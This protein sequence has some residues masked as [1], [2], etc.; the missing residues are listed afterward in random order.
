MNIEFLNDTFKTYFE[1]GLEAKKAGNIAEAKRLLLLAADTLKQIADKSEGDLKLSRQR[2]VLNIL[3]TI[4]G[5]DGN[6]T[7]KGGFSADD[8]DPDEKEDDCDLTVTTRKTADVSARDELN[9]LIGLSGVKESV[10]D[11]TNLVIARLEKERRG[12]KSN[13][14]LSLHLVFTGNPGT[15]KTTVARI[16]GEIYKELGLLSGGH[17]VE[18]DRANLVGQF[19]GHT[20]PLVKKAVAKAAGG[21]LF[22]DE[23]YTLS[24]GGNNDF[25]K[26]A[27]D[28]LLKEMEDKR[29]KFVVIVA[30]YKKEMEAF[31][32]SNPGLKSRFN[33]Y[34]Q[35]NDYAPGELFE[36]F[37]LMLRAREL[38]VTL[39]TEDYLREYFNDKFTSPPKNFANAREIRNIV[40]RIEFEQANRLARI[41]ASASDAELKTVMLDDVTKALAKIG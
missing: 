30:G 21:V 9:A 29:D 37:A 22:I 5:L 1:K 10:S 28:T 35:F 19:V 4:E 23:A 2:R 40:D 17:L 15:G 12:I 31:I 8:A 34:I 41:A 20:A 38:E 13:A 11:L 24:T 26:E 39:D 33:F 27:I 32:A 36:I 18:V 3:E 6:R 25:G 7:V 14:P 16:I